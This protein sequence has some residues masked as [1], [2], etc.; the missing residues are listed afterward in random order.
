M[1]FLFATLAL[2]LPVLVG[3]LWLHQV[4]PV[5]SAGRTALVWGNGALLGLLLIPRFMHGLDA[6][7][8]PLTFQATAS[9][10]GAL[11]ALAF[12]TQL[13]RGRRAQLLPAPVR[14]FAA[15]PASH[16]AL[17]AFLLLLVVVRATNLGL[18]ILWRPLFPWDATMH[19]ATKA[20]VWFEHNSLVPFVTKEAWLEM[21][22]AG[23][24]T[25]RHPDY[26]MTVPLLQ[27]WM[28]LAL[29]HWDESLMNLPWL[30]CLAA[31]GGAFYGQLRVSGVGP[32]IA[33]AFAYLLLS[34]P[35]LNIHVALAGYADL[36]LGAAYCGALMAFHNWVT[37]RQR[38]Q[39]ALALV[40]AL[41]CPLIKNEGLL[42]SLTFIPALM[43]T[44]LPHGVAARL[45]V[46]FS[47]VLILLWL[48]VPPDLQITVQ[49]A[50]HGATT[51]WLLP[52]PGLE[53]AGHP[54]DEMILEF[55]ADGLVGIVQSIWLHD[56]WHLMG[57]LLL[58]TLPVG[59]LLPGA[60]TRTY[61]QI[62]VA[63]GAAVM[64]F[65]FM[66]LC[67]GFGVAA[68]DFTGVG[69][70]GIQLAPALLFFSALLCNELLTRDDLQV[71]PLAQEL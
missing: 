24:F 71:K 9:L 34:L 55:H 61:L 41:A 4:V 36:F 5:N 19:W 45:C 60:M 59:L 66:F 20:R 38:W 11:I 21:G 16:K 2:A 33:M 37:T 53:I 12:V 35:L 49:I 51:Q 10:A 3:G 65:L 67:T 17:F 30:L 47:L 15:M 22:G 13:I 56:N 29:G 39:A 1:D 31:L 23:V 69:R 40:F 46:L 44:L 63:L 43:F 27:V 26:P 48:V 50:A 52:P 58:A 6:L 42:W 62:S 25:D 14:D 7:G 54:L 28:N 57:Y 18:E 68:S 70:I 64:V 32:V 8:I